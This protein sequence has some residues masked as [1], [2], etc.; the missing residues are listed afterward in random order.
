MYLDYT[1]SEVKMADELERMWKEAVL[2]QCCNLLERL[3][4]SV[5]FLSQ[6]L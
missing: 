5:K 2:V 4:N 1:A 3:K 6:D